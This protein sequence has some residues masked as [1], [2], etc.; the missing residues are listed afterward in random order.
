MYFKTLN[1]YIHYDSQNIN[2]EL[3]GYPIKENITA[4]TAKTPIL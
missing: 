4:Q 3:E 2:N 1:L